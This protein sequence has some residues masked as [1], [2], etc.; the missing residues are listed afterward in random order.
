[1]AEEAY[2]RHPTRYTLV[3]GLMPLDHIPGRKDTLLRSIQKGHYDMAGFYI[4]S[5]RMKPND[6]NKR[7]FLQTAVYTDSKYLVSLLIN[8]GVDVNMLGTV[9]ETSR[10]GRTLETMEQAL[11]F[12][13]AR[14]PAIHYAALTGNK[15]IVRML[16]NAGANVNILDSNGISSLGIAVVFGEIEI[17]KMLLNAG[18]NV[19]IGL[20]TL[21]NKK[22]PLKL[23]L[24]VAD[25]DMAEILIDYGANVTDAILKEFIKLHERIDDNYRE[26]RFKVI[27]I[28]KDGLKSSRLN[29]PVTDRNF[30]IDHDRDPLTL[31]NIQE[32][33]E[34][35][36]MN[37]NLNPYTKGS[38]EALLKTKPRKSPFT[39]KRIQGI[40]R[41]IRK[42]ARPQAPPASAPEGPNTNS[43]LNI[44]VTER[45]FNTDHDED[46]ITL[47][48]IKEGDEYYIINGKGH[49]YTRGS[50]EEL[51]RK[52]STSPNT[53]EDIK[54]ITRHIRRPVRAQA[55][56][57]SAPEGPNPNAVPQAGPQAP[58]ASAPEWVNPIAQPQAPPAFVNPK[59]KNA[60][61]LTGA[62]SPNA[63]NNNEEAVPAGGGKRTRKHRS[64]K[65]KSRRKA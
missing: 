51:L 33:E 59:A 16:I 61:P 4:T 27:E 49:P 28:I 5:T 15:D 31:A 36:M 18:A 21:F 1:M 54:N 43:R 24:E 35:Y 11:N 48:T 3:D 65:R 55:P 22:S 19:D 8:A 10:Y 58:P 25:P 50:M 34:Y 53:R 37:E 2:L 29:M 42:A 23:A 9:V 38:I 20:N 13:L 40:T 26:K 39:Q 45:N 62:V 57:A 52:N 44:P 56:P 30:N 6:F 60:V 12:K 7:A 32:G 17:A 47:D 41:H 14:A 46:P 64:K 63:R